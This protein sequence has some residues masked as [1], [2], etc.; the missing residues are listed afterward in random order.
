MKTSQKSAYAKGTM[1]NLHVQWKSF[2]IFCTYFKLVP[3]PASFETICTY[4]QFLSRSFKS[5]TSI[6]NYVNGV[7]VLHLLLHES[8][9]DLSDFQYEM[10]I[11]GIA[12]CN[13][14]CPKQASPITPQL[15]LKLYTTLDLHKPLHVACWA[16]YLI[17]FFLMARKSNWYLL[18]SRRLIAQN[19]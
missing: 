6:K 19:I 12:R 9:P 14:Y 17:G 7:K 16:A 1:R 4:T 13:P 2:F 3:V 18:V 5:T 8:F 10:L 11:K 15:L